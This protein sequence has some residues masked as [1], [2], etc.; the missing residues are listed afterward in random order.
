LLVSLLLATL[1]WRYVEQPFRAGG[2]TYANKKVFQSALVAMAAAILVGVGLAASG[3]LPGRLNAQQ[4]VMA[5]Y[6][7][8]NGD[9][10]YRGGQC[11]I[12]D[13]QGRYDTETCLKQDGQRPSILLLGDSHAAQLW[14]G[15]HQVA[16]GYNV[17][18]AT[19]TGCRPVLTTLPLASQPPCEQLFREV[20]ANWLPAHPVQL[21]ILAGR[22][23]PADVPNLALTVAL[24]RQ[25]AATVMVV[26]P[27]PQYASSL[28]RVL[29]R[30]E[31]HPERVA[32][33]LVSGP[34]LLDPQ[35][36]KVAQEA[37]A[38][39]VSL[40]EQLCHG[41][42]CRTLAAA[43]VPLQFDYGHLTA[44]GSAVVAAQLLHRGANAVASSAAAP[45]P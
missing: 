4:Q 15:L 33:S 42:D 43:G 35:M 23:T 32:A 41:R 38:Q 30:S 29:V 6:E 17:L 20:L 10:I 11:F 18:Q 14:P 19:Q 9:Q 28:P 21:V 27:I 22:W 8:Y 37:G 25:H 12:V 44:Q 3:G 16:T 40:L 7:S 34:F 2:S 26:G 13:G 31:G 24:A 5:R 1:S 36:R 39:Y 45:P